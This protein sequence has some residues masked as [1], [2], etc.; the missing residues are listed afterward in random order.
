V[1]VGKTHIYWGSNGGS[2]D[3]I[4]RANVDGSGVNENFITFGS[5]AGNEFGGVAVTE[6]HVY[7]TTGGSIGRASIDA[8]DVIESSIPSSGDVYGVAIGRHPG[9]T[10]RNHAH[11]YWTSN[12][13]IGRARLDGTDV[14][15]EFITPP[16]PPSWGLAV[17]G[18]HIYWTNATSLSAGTIARARVDGTAIDENFIAGLTEPWSVAIHVT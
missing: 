8:A 3:Q 12:G 5:S 2:E 17:D 11:I 18:S 13:A 6:S 9:S 15:G 4:G 7:W 1:A 14:N 10:E 16:E